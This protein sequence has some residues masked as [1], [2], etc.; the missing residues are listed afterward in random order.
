[1]CAVD[2]FDFKFWFSIIIMCVSMYSLGHVT[3]KG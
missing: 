2:A 3:K 1:M